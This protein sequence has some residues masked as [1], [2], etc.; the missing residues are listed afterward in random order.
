[1]PSLKIGEFWNWEDEELTVF[2]LQ[3]KGNYHQVAVSPNLPDLPLHEIK[4]FM[5]MS[6]EMDDTRVIRLFREWVRGRYGS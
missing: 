5:L 4:R 1:M 3:P 6:R 2:E